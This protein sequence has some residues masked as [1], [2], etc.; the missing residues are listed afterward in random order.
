MLAWVVISRLHPRRS[1]LSRSFRLPSH[2]LLFTIVYPL[3]IQPLR[4]SSFRNSFVLNTIHFDGGGCT[5]QRGKK[6]NSTTTNSSSTIEIPA[7][8][9]KSDSPLPRPSKQ[10]RCTHR[11]PNGKR[12]RNSA[13]H[14]HF[15]LCLNH[16]KESAAI[17]VG[18]QQM[19]NYS[20]DLS[21]ELLPELSQFNS[22][23]DINKF[24]ARLLVLVTKGRVSPRRASV[25]AYVT[26]QLLHSHRAIA[27]D[28]ALQPQ[29]QDQRLILDYRD[30]P[31]PQDG[32][33]IK[34]PA[35]YR[36]AVEAG[37]LPDPRSPAS[38]QEARIV[39]TRV[40]ETNVSPD[41]PNR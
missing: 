39:G 4:K 3:S 10:G 14:S 12:C 26:N 24:L 31:D 16:F 27:P 2:L 1:P 30:S 22:G 8:T 11:F 25:L 23:V 33:G 9:S 29:Q 18:L 5:P 34:G 35:C 21:A 13:S 36:R 19:P 7:V 41:R 40:M 28:K 17:G 20:A 38:Q 37:I 6:M 15:G 32:S